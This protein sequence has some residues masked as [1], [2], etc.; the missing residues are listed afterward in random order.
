MGSN[1]VRLSDILDLSCERP[2]A[3]SADVSSDSGRF[4]IVLLRHIT[5]NSILGFSLLL[6]MYFTCK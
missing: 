3:F 6:V 4:V 5:F 1:E 2:I